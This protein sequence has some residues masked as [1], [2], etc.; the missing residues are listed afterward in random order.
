MQ[1]S[2]YRIGVA[3]PLLVLGVVPYC[4]SLVIGSPWLLWFGF[5]FIT[6][7]TGDILVLWL[8]RGID[9]KTLVEDH[10][11]NAG[12]YVYAKD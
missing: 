5:V 7:A 11:S 12:C 4:V 9:G 6:A 8:L 3:M 2:A 1:A 10:P